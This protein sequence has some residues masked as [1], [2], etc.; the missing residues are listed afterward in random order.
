MDGG[1]SERFS[2]WLLVLREHDLACFHEQLGD[3]CLLALRYA[4]CP[5]S[6]WHEI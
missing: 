2:C 6:E 4:L 5:L 3:V 1:E